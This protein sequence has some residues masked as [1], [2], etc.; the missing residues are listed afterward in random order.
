VRV[1]KRGIR[2]VGAVLVVV[3]VGLTVWYVSA[4]PKGSDGYRERM[5]ETTRTVRSQVQ[6]ARLWAA[7]FTAGDSLSAPTAVALEEA[8]QDASAAASQF[9]SYEPPDGVIALRARF[10][11]LA[12]EATGALADLRIAAQREEWRRLGVLAEPL[13]ALA[14][15]LARFERRARP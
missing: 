11:S 14:V 10:V 15:R 5:G 8:D 7:A 2:S 12:S 3:L 9:E 1:A 4:P 6:S 13:D